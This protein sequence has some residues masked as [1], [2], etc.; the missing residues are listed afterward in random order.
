MG[1]Y[2]THE[3]TAAGPGATFGGS[4]STKRNKLRGNKQPGPA[5][6][7]VIGAVHATK[8][9]STHGCSGFGGSST[10]FPSSANG[11]PGPSYYGI[12]HIMNHDAG[13]V[14]YSKR[15]RYVYAKKASRA[16]K[17]ARASAQSRP[18]R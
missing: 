1:M 2:S 6:Y 13:N 4:A 11:K 7:D 10:R 17:A 14:M 15:G 12:E 5:A 16:A 3:V 8:K 18:R 9:R